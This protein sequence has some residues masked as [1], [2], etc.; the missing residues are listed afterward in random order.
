MMKKIMALFLMFVFSSAQI[1]FATDYQAYKNYI[2]ATLDLKSGD[3]KSAQKEL[4]KVIDKDK[5]A[6]AAYKDLSHIYAV[7]GDKVAATAAAKKIEE[8]DGDNPLTTNFLAGIYFAME[9]TGTAKTFWDKTLVLDPENENAI[10]Y[11]ASYYAVD[12]QELEKSAI[13]WKHFLRQQPDSAPG[14]Y[15]LGIVQERQGKTDEAKKS[16]DKAISLKPETVDAY[17]AKA[18]IYEAEKQYLKAIAEYEN[19]SKYAPGNPFIYIFEGKN[20][21]ELGKYKEA[22]EL[23]LTAKEIKNADSY[24][25]SSYWLGMVY[26]KTWAID[27][28]AAEF[29]D[30]A[31]VENNPMI[32]AK[33]GYYYSLLKKYDKAEKAFAKALEKG[34]SNSELEYL[35]ALNYLDWSKY[36]KA[37]ELFKKVVRARPTYSEG[38]FFLGVTYNNLGDSESAQAS[39]Q[40]AIKLDPKNAKAFNYLGYTLVENNDNLVLAEEYI[41]R[42][43]ELEKNNGHYL[44]SLGRLHYKLGN[45]EY[46]AQILLTAVGLARD[47]L[48]YEHLG[49]SCMKIQKYSEAWV[50]YALAYDLKQSKELKAKMDQ[51]QKLMDKKDFYKQM[52]LRADSNYLKIPSLKAGYTANVGFLMFGSKVYLRFD[53]QRGQGASIT[54]PA[55]LG[56]SGAVITIAGGNISYEPAVVE[57]TIPEEFSGVI[58]LAADLFNTGLMK[59]FSNAQVSEKKGKIIYTI[60]DE[61][62]ILNAD[63]AMIEKI[64]KA[65]MSA[66]LSNFKEFMQS[67]LPATIKI[68]SKDF[69]V[70]FETKEFSVSDKKINV[71]PK[72]EQKK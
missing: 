24:K 21:F 60:D 47:P 59:R 8:L 31:K 67:K 11:L 36:D 29:E 33:L 71:K 23:F 50:S 63:T 57:L 37:L 44:D 2:K 58:E 32:D 13:H 3:A 38:F 70:T 22:E 61:E 20:Y 66:E 65:K 42:A 43:V 68:K 4:E 15:Q 1:S 45:Y 9:D 53:F 7:T 28:A 6:F 51:S 34:G 69:K 64:S 5:S 26:E 35:M 14:Y 18:R 72:A 39:L 46:S 52:L 12:G 25:M 56:F 62:L 17:A 41:M 49:D 27:K 55:T 40:T 54:I 48:I 30:L 16:F 10:V 19:Y